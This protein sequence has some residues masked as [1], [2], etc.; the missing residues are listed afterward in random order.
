MRRLISCWRE[1][2]CCRFRVTNVVLLCSAGLSPLVGT[3]ISIM[4]A[5]IS[6]NSSGSGC[7]WHGPIQVAFQYAFRSHKRQ[8]F[9]DPWSLSF[10]LGGEQESS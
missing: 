2:L 9:A 1:Q 5:Y 8:E 4:L 3:P 6:I 7:S 10:D